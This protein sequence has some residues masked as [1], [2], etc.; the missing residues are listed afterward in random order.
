M[1][2]ELNKPGTGVT[3]SNQRDHRI[4]YF[5]GLL[6]GVVLRKKWSP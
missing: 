2:E 1:F 6:V 3:D 4:L 5:L